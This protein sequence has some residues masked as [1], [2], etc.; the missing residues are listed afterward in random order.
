MLHSRMQHGSQDCDTP[1]EQGPDLGEVIEDGH[2][3]EVLHA[4]VQAAQGAAR[5][6][7][8]EGLV[9]ELDLLAG[10]REH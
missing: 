8:A 9:Q 10:R 5:A 7:P 3:L 6:Q 4:A 2:A 1:F